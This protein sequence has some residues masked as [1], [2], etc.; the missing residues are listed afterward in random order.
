MI[1]PLFRDFVSVCLYQCKAVSKLQKWMDLL[2]AIIVYDRISAGCTEKFQ[3][4]EIII[5]A[6]MD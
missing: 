4:P 2:T 1:G 3:L 5:P 6:F